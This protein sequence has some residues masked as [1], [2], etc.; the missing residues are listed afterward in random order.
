MPKRFA[1]NTPEA[2]QSGIIYTLLAGIKDFIEAWLQNFSESKIAI[3][4]GDRNLLFNYLKLQYPQIVA[5][6]IVEKNLILWGIQ[7][8]IM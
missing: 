1:I 8:T 6:I 4:G 2:I 5:K 3:T 7:K